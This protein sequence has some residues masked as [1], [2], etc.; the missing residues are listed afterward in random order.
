MSIVCLTRGLSLIGTGIIWLLNL[1]C[2][3]MWIMSNILRYTGQLSFIKDHMDYVLL[4]ILVRVLLLSRLMWNLL[5]QKNNYL[6]G[7][8]LQRKYGLIMQNYAAH[9]RWRIQM[10]YNFWR[11][12]LLKWKISWKIVSEHDQ[13][14]PQSQTADNPVHRKEEPLN[15][16][17]TPGRQIEQSNQLSL[18]HKDDCNTRMDIKLRTTKQEQL[19]TPPMGATINKKSTTTEPPP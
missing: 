13:E 8:A 7:G 5:E 14:I 1:A 16:H 9:A 6:I 4:L 12:D 10:V 17:E 3:L 15:H 19:Q 2:L 18:P 11:Q